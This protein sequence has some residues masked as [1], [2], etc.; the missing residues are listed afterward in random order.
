MAKVKKEKKV[1]IDITAGY[2]K[3]IKGKQ[4]NSNG[5]ELFEQVIKKATVSK[6]AKQR[7]LK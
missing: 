2:E 1:T 4:T 5:K 3:F 6:P 7:G